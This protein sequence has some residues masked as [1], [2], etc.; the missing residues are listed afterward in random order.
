M[1]F[2]QPVVLGNADIL[3]LG[4]MMGISSATLWM[5]LKV[6]YIPSGEGSKAM[7]FPGVHPKIA[8]NSECSSPQVE[9]E[10]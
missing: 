9:Y 8:A 1:G 6:R 2:T 3:H 10:S 5:C 4:K 7:T